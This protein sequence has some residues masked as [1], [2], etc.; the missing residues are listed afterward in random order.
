LE[1]VD[2]ASTSGALTYASDPKQMSGKLT[3]CR[4]LD[5]IFSLKSLG[6]STLDL[7]CDPA[8]HRGGID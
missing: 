5:N 6:S 8:N 3:H 7:S 1:S 4:N 2:I